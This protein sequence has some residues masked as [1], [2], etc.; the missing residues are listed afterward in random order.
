MNKLRRGE[1]NPAAAKDSSMSGRLSSSTQ[2]AVH[3]QEMA[4]REERLRPARVRYAVRQT[5]K[6]LGYLPACA[7]TIRVASDIELADLNRRFRRIP[8]A[9]DV[10]SFP[11]GEVD[12]DSGRIY[13]G[14]IVL[15][16]PRAKA[17]AR[18]AGHS[19]EREVLLLIVHGM[20]HLFGFD[21]NSAARKRK[22]WMEQAKILARL[23]P[24]AR[25]RKEE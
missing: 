8:R 11:S 23:D 4:G 14:D 7:V 16:L 19:L 21:H 24:P 13:L 17:Q 20:L 5:V 10:L 15:S 22:M 3:Y 25:A 12:P 1:N 6:E 2:V 9:T 18:R